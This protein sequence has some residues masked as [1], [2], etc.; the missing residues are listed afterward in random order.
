M[1]GHFRLSIDQTIEVFT[2]FTSSMFS[3]RRSSL[4]AAISVANGG[5]RYSTPTLKRLIADLEHQITGEKGN[6]FQI[7]A[8]T[9]CKT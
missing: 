1:L 7:G 4:R 3:K 2:K 5:S 8:N 9:A 6:P